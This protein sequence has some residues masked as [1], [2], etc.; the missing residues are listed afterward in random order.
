M[1]PYVVT[2]RYGDV[3]YEIQLEENGIPRVVHAN[4]LKPYTGDDSPP[5]W[6]NQEDDQEKES[7]DSEV[8]GPLG[9]DEDDGE[10]GGIKTPPASEV[11]EPGEEEPEGPLGSD[12]DYGEK[13]GNQAPPASEVPESG[14]GEPEHAGR[15]R[16]VR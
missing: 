14:E 8:E 12:E 7:F 10:K 9:S 3:T 13:G 1:G 2:A 5:N 15:S 4:H 16:R 11:P 6:L